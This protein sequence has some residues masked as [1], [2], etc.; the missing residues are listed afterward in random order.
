MNLIGLF[1]PEAEELGSDE[2]ELEG[3]K[4]VI[5]LKANDQ[6]KFLK[7]LEIQQERSRGRVILS[8]NKGF[9][10]RSIL[11]EFVAE[12]ER[13]PPMEETAESERIKTY[14]PFPFV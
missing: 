11:N 14:A 4:I 13:L 12:Y 2:L 6:G 9:E 3:K 1:V 5:E 8:S 7:V 10:L